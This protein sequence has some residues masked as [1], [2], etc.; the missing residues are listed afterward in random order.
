MINE[1]AATQPAEAR[2]H[3]QWT[4]EDL[5][6]MSEATMAIAA[7]SDSGLLTALLDAELPA[8][9]LAADLNL[10]HT[11]CGLVLDVLSAFGA[12]ERRDDRFTASDS[13][14]R[15]AAAP[16]GIPFNVALWKH[17]SVFLRTGM[18]VAAMDGPAEQRGRHFTGVVGGLP[19]FFG[20]IPDQVARLAGAGARSILDIGAGSGVWSMAVAALDEE[21]LVTGL[22]LAAVVPVLLAHAE[23]RGLD[24]RVTAL[25]ADYHDA[26]FPPGQDLVFLANVLHLEEPAAARDLIQRAALALRCGGRLA[27]IDVFRD[28]SSPPNRMQ[29]MYALSLAMR[30][31]GGRVPRSETVTAWLTEAGLGGVRRYGLADGS[32]AGEL[33]GLILAEKP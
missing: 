29:A 8:R 22:D 12:A 3:A 6:D 31:R 4:L 28:A 26:V 17:Q 2:A 10:D 27:V 18:P 5:F 7:A 19:G 1:N 15:L 24:G 32:P 30:T 16:A 11:A 25:A 14:R 23:A 20:A 13:L 21:A 9:Q 33:I